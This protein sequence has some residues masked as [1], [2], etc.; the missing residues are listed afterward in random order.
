MRCQKITQYSAFISSITSCIFDLS[1]SFPQHIQIGGP[2]YCFNFYGSTEINKRLDE[3]LDNLVVEPTDKLTEAIF[4]TA[5]CI[6]DLS[7]DK[8]FPLSDLNNVNSIIDK[9][10]NTLK[11][12]NYNDP[13]SYNHFHDT[14]TKKPNQ[15]QSHI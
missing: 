6:A 11:N 8:I 9:L 3:N 14:I 1:K 12:I 13:D 15:L 4:S 2:E 5:S 7:E 10:L